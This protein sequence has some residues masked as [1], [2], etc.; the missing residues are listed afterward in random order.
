M[1]TRKTLSST[2]VHPQALNTIG[3]SNLDVLNQVEAAIQKN[4]VVVIGMSGN[5]FVKKMR[6][7]LEKDSVPFEYMEF[8]SYL[9]DWKKRLTI[10]LWSGWPTFPQVF[11]DGVLLGGYEDTM[12]LLKSGEVKL[13]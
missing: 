12:K 9:S 3:S 8:G 1:T 6:S 7:A 2:K 4:K 11:V 5:P 10:K 13:K